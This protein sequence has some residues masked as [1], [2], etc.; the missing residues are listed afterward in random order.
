[1]AVL[2][3]MTGDT[4]GTQFPLVAERTIVGRHPTCQVVLNS[5]VVS[6]QHAQILENHG[7]FYIEDLSS[8]NGTLVNQRRITGRTELNDGDE[9]QLCDVRLSFNQFPSGAF[10]LNDGQKSSDVELNAKPSSHTFDALKSELLEASRIL[11]EPANNASDFDQGTAIR[12]MPQD[13]TFKS[14]VD[15][16]VRLKAILELTY[17]LGREL[18]VEK[19]LPKVLV[20]LFS[21]F[22]QAE[23]GFVLLKDPE[24]GRLKVK[25]SRTRGGSEAE[26]VAISMT[27]VRHALQ[28]RESI[29][30][31]NVSDDSRFRKSTA[32][33]KMQI[34]S[35]M[36]VPLLNQ[37]NE[38]LGVIQI[39][40]R[41]GDRA[42]SEEDLDLLA[43]LA[44]QASMAIENARLHEEDVHRRELERDLEFATQVQLGFLPK[45]RPILPG[46]SFHDYYEAALSV[47][48]DYFDYLTLADGRV[49]MAIGD[50][51]G[52]GMPAAL[53]MARLYSS[54]RLQ[55]L[56]KKTL[57]EAV[58]GLNEEISSSG[59]GHRFITFLVMIIDPVTQTLQI[60]NAGHLPPLR[61][62]AD[63]TVTPL[64]RETSS[65][66]L[67][68]MA[69]LTFE[70]DTV[71]FAPGDTIIAYTDGVTEAMSSARTIYGNE[72][73]ISLIEKCDGNISETVEKIIEDVE[74]FT[75]TMTSRDDT[76]IIGVHRA[77]V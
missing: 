20:T 16:H 30:S 25:A 47:G 35:M 46:Y 31:R 72:K 36:C 42:F 22:P 4:Q 10:A 37:E 19:V 45:S 15:P 24:T 11:G 48:G 64:A 43:S 28:T 75:G 52:K 41:D 26:T 60:V 49:A 67:G 57:E 63:G 33:T 55:L 53:L 62:S 12:R 65:L 2:L 73:L 44:T 6:R 13:G 51:A 5:N 3:L 56:T 66:P 21:I 54:M 9:I 1:M 8:R 74:E 14:T 77:Q 58:A 70:S 40:T 50:V 76:C 29:L 34:T 7:T 68:I 27:V 38:G 59:L 69:D 39:V 18:H 71:P 17:A 61:R 23:Q 32:L